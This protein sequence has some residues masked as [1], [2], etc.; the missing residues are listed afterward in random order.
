MLDQYLLDE[1]SGASDLVFA[2]HLDEDVLSAIVE[3]RIWESETEIIRH[4]VACTSCRKKTADL[5]RL[6]S[7]IEPFEAPRTDDSNQP[8][9]VRKLLEDLIAPPSPSFEDSVYAY[10]AE[11]DAAESGDSIKPEEQ[12]DDPA[13]RGESE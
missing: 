3:G 12:S 9:R 4:L 1:H 13:G 10:H 2:D 6:E 11:D 8:G 7:E 5:V